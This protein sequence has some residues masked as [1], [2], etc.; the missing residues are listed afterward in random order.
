MYVDITY[1]IATLQL[2][3][4]ISW[5]LTMFRLLKDYRRVITRYE[6]AKFGPAGNKVTIEHYLPILL[7]LFHEFSNPP[8]V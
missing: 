3:Q 5:K 7:N 1:I 6:I 2:F 8:K 4:Q